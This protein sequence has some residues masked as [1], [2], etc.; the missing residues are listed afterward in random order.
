MP[1]SAATVL[2][3]LKSQSQRN[4]ATTIECFVTSFAYIKSV[5]S[6]IDT[7]KRIQKVAHELVLLGCRIAS[8]W[9]ESEI[10]SELS[11]QILTECLDITED[12]VSRNVTLDFDL[13]I[14][15]LFHLAEAARQCGKRTDAIRHIERCILLLKDARFKGQLPQS[16]VLHMCLADLFL[17]DGQDD[18]AY[19]ASK[20]ACALTKARGVSGLSRDLFKY[21]I[22]LSLYF[23]AC[24]QVNKVDEA[25]HVLAL[26]SGVAMIASRRFRGP[27]YKRISDIVETMRKSL[28]PQPVA[29]TMDDPQIIELLRNL[30]ISK[31]DTAGV[32][33]ELREALKKDLEIDPVI[34][35]DD[36]A[37]DLKAALEEDAGNLNSDD[38]YMP[39]IRR[40]VARSFRIT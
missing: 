27:Q 21:A 2:R 7:D 18:K 10:R 23:Q 20:Q 19:I 30:E 37:A 11:L 5:Q 22:S 34:N 35:M 25:R 29:G 8:E 32:E 12:C 24:L 14:R 39:G 26:A 3:E 40:Q 38:D 17:E 13:L 33:S 9:I 31:E 16:D 15:V 36:V 1:T 28:P 6:H 4:D